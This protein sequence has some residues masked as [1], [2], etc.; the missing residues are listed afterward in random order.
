MMLV[1]T[2]LE[3][4]AM[5]FS[6]ESRYWIKGAAMAAVY[7]GRRFEWHSDSA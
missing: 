5:L 6:T 4:E 2:L 7:E 1:W 3:Q